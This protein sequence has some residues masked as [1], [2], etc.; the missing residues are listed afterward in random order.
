MEKIDYRGSEWRKWDLHIH[1]P[2]SL[3][4]EYG[5]NTPEI[6]ET[7]FDKLEALSKDI[8]VIGINDYLFI[9]G[10]EKVLKRKL[11]GGLRK[12][13]LI[14]P[15][16]EFRIREFV[17]NSKLSK[18]NYHVIFADNSLLSI[19]QINSHFLTQLR[20]KAN[21]DINNPE[22]HSWSGIIS[23]DTLID[24]GKA[25]YDNTPLGY[26][27]N[28]NYLYIGFNSISFSTETITDLLGERGTPNNYLKGKY[29]KAIGKAEWEDYR[30]DSG[31]A[32]KNTII[33]DAHF[34]FTASPTPEM[35]ING[36][37]NL[38][39]QNVNSR[40]LHC[41]DAHKFAINE[42][43]I[44]PKEL[45]H[46]YNWIK[47]DSTFEGLK[48]VLYEPDERIKVQITKPDFKSDRN[49]I[50]EVCFVDKSH[51]FGNKTIPINE[52]LNAVI[53]GKSS[54]KSL[55]LY[56]IANSIDPDQ[57]FRTSKRLGSDGYEFSNG[58]DFIVKWKNGDCDYYSN[59]NIER[60]K[61]AITYIPQLYI[62]HLA[63]KNK[64]EEL[65]ALIKGILLQDQEFCDYYHK[66]KSIIDDISVELE[67]ALTQYLDIRKNILEGLSDY[68]E[69]GKSE[70]I[71]KSIEN[72]ISEVD[73]AHQATSHTE[74]EIIQYHALLLRKDDTEKSI[75]SN[76]LAQDA[77]NQIREEIVKSKIY[78]FGDDFNENPYSKL[79]QIKK[80]IDNIS[81]E[82]KFEELIIKIKNNFNTLIDNYSKEVEGFGLIEKI[83]L[84]KEELDLVNR[85]LLPIKKKFKEQQ[86]VLK[87]DDL[88]AAE[89]KKYEKSLDIERRLEKLKKEYNAKRDFSRHL[90]EK[91]FNIYNK[92][93]H[94]INNT[95]D[96]ITSD[97]TLNCKLIINKEDLPLFH[98]VNKSAIK[99]NSE[100]YN[101]FDNEFVVYEKILD[102]FGYQLSVNSDGL[103]IPQKEKISLKQKT[104]LED[105]LRG[106][107]KDLF[108]I[109]YS[110][111]YKGDD[112]LRMSPG[113]KGTV[114]LIL[115][116]QISS[117]NSPIIID[118]PEDNLDNRTIYDLLCRIIKE[119]KKYR[120]ILIVSHNANLV[121]AT[122]AENIIIANQ[123]GQESDMNEHRTRF[124]YINGSIEN[125]YPKKDEIDNILRSQGIKEHICDILEGGSDAF[126]Q[127][128][129]KYSIK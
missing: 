15:V 55:L 73:K 46:C 114:L 1:T 124:D 61:H 115:L 118:Q 2:A 4:S 28:N 50:K 66:T 24:L 109:D 19:E 67:S 79:G 100:F 3:C 72:L 18:I 40:V 27:K 88:L 14:L 129:R 95:R 101:L 96:K 16:I 34:I 93:V 89:K 7:F 41:S 71:K 111:T 12:I 52:N 36:M 77:L 29:F 116:L 26:R 75:T 108:I 6:W 86:E 21:L 123:E 112:L 76:E 8:S 122:D 78:L 82:Y 117:A 90:L 84:L 37:N 98:Q 9:D 106:M 70:N 120:Q 127:R 110:I 33:N 23:R 64:K 68:N 65:N 119:K 62:N 31:G 44:S 103:N 107:T 39:N 53:G 105:V 42:L 54:G 63:E 80:I 81:E 43:K 17:G 99:D 22:T 57:V 74:A 11:E 10:Y 58:F 102:L 45:G 51:L 104:T 25:V 35:A 56:A 13:D 126:K 60:E 91:R 69:I 59:K 47:A 97:I 5:G 38:K 48:Q 87:L 83:R 94:T 49:V 125:T 92:L 30:W 20:A 128:E 113:K 121:V 85:D 32:D